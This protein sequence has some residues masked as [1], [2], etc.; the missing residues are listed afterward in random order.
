MMTLFFGKCFLTLDNTNV[1]ACPVWARRG[2]CIY[3][4][5]GLNLWLVCFCY[6]VTEGEPRRGGEPLAKKDKRNKWTKQSRKHY[7]S[8]LSFDLLFYI[9]RVVT[10]SGLLFCCCQWT[11]FCMSA[12]GVDLDQGSALGYIRVHLEHAWES[13]RWMRVHESH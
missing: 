2:N 12:L 11:P 10:L 1:V 5:R 8:Q 9:I 7:W 4:V 3:F 13:L 6:R